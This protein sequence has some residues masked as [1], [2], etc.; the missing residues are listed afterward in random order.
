MRK[1]IDP[2]YDTFPSRASEDVV[3][4]AMLGDD[5]FAAK[6]VSAGLSVR[7]FVGSE[8]SVLAGV[9]LEMFSRRGSVTLE[10]VLSDLGEKG[11]SDRA[12]GKMRVIELMSA[13]HG[14]KEQFD[15][16]E[17]LILGD[18]LRTF[19][20]RVDEL[21]SK[22][23]EDSGKSLLERVEVMEDGIGRLVGMVGNGD[24]TYA[25]PQQL[26]ELGLEKADGF[27]PTGFPSLDERIHGYVPGRVTIVAARTSHGK[28]A[29]CLDM[30][31]RQAR[32][33]KERGING[34]ILYFSAEMGAKDVAKRLIANIAG[35]NSMTLMNGG[36]WVAKDEKV[37]DGYHK[38]RKMGISVDA[39][40]APTTAYIL[41]RAIAAGHINPVRLIV[42]DYLEYTGEKD[43]QKDLRLEKA[44]IGC[45]EIAKRVGC[46]FIVVSQLN[47]NLELR[48]VDAEPQL[49]DLRYTGAAE[50]IAANVTMLYHEWTHWYQRRHQG[51]AYGEDEPDQHRYDIFV[52]KN[53]H[54]PLGHAQIDFYR[55][56]GRFVDP[57][58]NR[59]NNGEAPF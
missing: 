55:E 2:M 27:V 11:L 35:V 25:N 7:C 54:G 49:S 30:C 21:K 59:Q 12:G 4:G 46:P 48:G 32:S 17:R 23:F 36:D 19:S 53:T 45:H 56:T 13:Y 16:L 57:F 47:R 43:R 15:Q 10:G 1:T 34:Q 50:N 20:M 29:F 33:M 37:I 42:F 18:R 40:P 8:N 31:L 58:D 52:R 24:D 6:A 14:E 39:H 41:G 9:I 3:L 28:T 26:A 51:G 44:L 22:V 5:K 38:L